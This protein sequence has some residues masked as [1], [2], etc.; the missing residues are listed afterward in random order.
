MK[1]TIN[2]KEYDFFF[3][4]VWGPMYLYE[5]IAGEKMPF[6]PR[7]TA[8]LHVLFYCILMRANPGLEVTL[9]EFLMSLNNLEMANG[10]RNYYVKRMNVLTGMASDEDDSGDDKKKE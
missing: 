4:S 8:C 3:D 1:V 2:G 6:D 7:K 9:E 10:M 5:E